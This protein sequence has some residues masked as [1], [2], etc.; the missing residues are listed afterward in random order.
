M[1][2]HFTQIGACVDNGRSFNSTR[3]GFFQ[4]VQARANFIVLSICLLSH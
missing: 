1:K 2:Y 3:L 4:L